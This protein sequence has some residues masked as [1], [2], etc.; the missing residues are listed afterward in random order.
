M[1]VFTHVV[2]ADPAALAMDMTVTL[3]TAV[4]GEDGGVPVASYAFT[5]EQV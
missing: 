1:R 3:T 5:P 2:G 4:L